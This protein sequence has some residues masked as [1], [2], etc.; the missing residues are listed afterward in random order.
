MLVFWRKYRAERR[1]RIA[2]EEKA[3]GQL[4][5]LEYYYQQ[6]QP[7]IYATELSATENA[8]NELPEK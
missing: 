7:T 2:A 6:P 1:L 4:G 3:Q 8:R 5:G